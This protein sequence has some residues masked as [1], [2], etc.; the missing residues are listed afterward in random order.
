MAPTIK[1]LHRTAHTRCRKLCSTLK[2]YLMKKSIL[3]LMATFLL[4]L[5]VPVQLSAHEDNDETKAPVQSELQARVDILVE[6]L[7]EIESMDIPSLKSTEKR[8]LKKEVRTIHKEL[9]S[10]N[11]NPAN[12][13]VNIPPAVVGNGV[14][15]SVGGLII[16]ILLLI[17]LL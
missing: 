16:I 14:Y 2:L 17:L 13:P 3:I 11:E 15:I 12:P 8:A 7:V 5:F 6:R 9:K 1:T 10:I 4:L